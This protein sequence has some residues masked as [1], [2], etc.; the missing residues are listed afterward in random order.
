MVDTSISALHD[1]I[2]ESDF[3]PSIQIIGILT[4]YAKNE[5]Y[6]KIVSFLINSEH[7]IGM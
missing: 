7:L 3:R 6:D 1:A 4:A 2:D 5:Q